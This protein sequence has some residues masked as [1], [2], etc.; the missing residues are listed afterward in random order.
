MEGLLRYFQK[1]MPAKF[2]T[3]PDY[4]VTL[5]DQVKYDQKKMKK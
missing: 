4:L 2:E 3:D 5:S 1:E